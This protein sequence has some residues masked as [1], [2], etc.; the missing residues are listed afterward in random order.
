MALNPNP[1][2]SE[3]NKSNFDEL[4]RTKAAKATFIDRAPVSADP[5]SEYWQYANG[6]TNLKHWKRH[7]VSGAWY[8]ATYS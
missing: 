7:P 3:D 1:T 8:S 2:G 4:Q 5:G 6:G